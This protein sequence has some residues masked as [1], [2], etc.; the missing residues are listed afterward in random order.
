[1][2]SEPHAT[3]TEGPGDVAAFLA[4]ELS[5]TAAAMEDY[6]REKTSSLRPINRLQQWCDMV[7][8]Q[9]PP[10]TGVVPLY[11]ISRLLDDAL[12]N[13]V[14][15]FHYD[16]HSDRLRREFFEALV[17]DLHALSTIDLERSVDWVPILQQAIQRYIQ[18]VSELDQYAESHV[19]M[20]EEEAT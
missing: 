6:G 12:D 2:S 1:M 10:T 15:D 3:V 19:P 11:L 20:S 18:V 8:T 4:R 16:V 9:A 7:M 13:L 17:L 14:G 5:A